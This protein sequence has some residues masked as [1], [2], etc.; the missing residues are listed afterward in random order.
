MS[1]QRNQRQADVFAWAQ[2]AF[3]VE[4][5]TSLPQRGLR[6]LEEAIEA[7]QATGTPEDAR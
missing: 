1:M 7:F 5:A 3:T 2:A 4:Q 6:L